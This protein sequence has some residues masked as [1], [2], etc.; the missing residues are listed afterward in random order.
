MMKSIIPIKIL[1]F[2]V[3]SGLIL[4]SCS[5][6]EKILK[7]KDYDLKYNKALEYF[8]KG[9]YYHSTALF[10]QL[11][12]IYK[13]TQ[14]SDTVEYYLAIGNYHQGD[15]LLAGHYF[16][17]F[18]KTFPRSVFTEDAEFM[19]AYC[20]YQSSPRAELDQDNTQAA[21]SAFAEFLSRYPNSE[22]V[23]EVTDIM[24]ELKNKLIYKAYLSAKLYYTI[25]EYK[26][27][28][29]AFKNSLKDYPMSSYRE[30][31]LYLILKSSYLLA[32]NSVPKKRK[33]R[34]QSTID[35][36]YTLVGEYPD[37]QYL[38]DAK[39]MYENSVKI[40]GNQNK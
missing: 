15:F 18:R 10:E 37:T 7:S 33:E 27:A 24:I 14:Q 8:V 20:Y 16:D 5:G 12:P 36:Y 40:L 23:Q 3:I 34:F 35:E 31:Q 1:L 39:R 30:E 4:A 13:G 9:D 19:Y 6:Y 11:S 22:R 38:K 21:L 29:V 2:I 32:D 25:G 26:A 28:I 17:K